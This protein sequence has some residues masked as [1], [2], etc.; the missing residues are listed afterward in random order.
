MHNSEYVFYC[1]KPS[2][3]NGIQVPFT[4]G[5]QKLMQC[6][7]KL[8]Y[9]HNG[10]ISMDATFGTND[11]KYHLFTLMGFDVHHNKAILTW[12][13]T[14]QQTMNEL[15]EWLQPLKVKMSSIMPNWRPSCIII[16]DAPQE[17]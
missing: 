8:A 15:I 17:L 13:I 14:S 10:A 3:I 6:H 16:N 12:T 9:D 11:V 5:I 7:S 2:E 4:L 1:Q